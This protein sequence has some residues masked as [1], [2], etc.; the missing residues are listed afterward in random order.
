MGFGRMRRGEGRE[1]E[2]VEQLPH[3][4][5]H[6]RCLAPSLFPLILITT[7]SSTNT[8]WV[9]GPGIVLGLLN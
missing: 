5:L 6:T 8:Y 2:F 7:Q 3:A 1:G 9:P 4:R